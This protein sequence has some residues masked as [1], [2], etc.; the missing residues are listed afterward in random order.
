M[1]LHWENSFQLTA[2]LMIMSFGAGVF[3]SVL[4]MKDIE[5][6]RREHFKRELQNYPEPFVTYDDVKFFYTRI[7]LITNLQVID[8]T[9][10]QRF[11]DLLMVA[12]DLYRSRHSRLIILLNYAIP[13]V[14]RPSLDQIGWDFE[15]VSD[16]TCDLPRNRCETV[17]DYVACMSAYSVAVKA[18]NRGLSL[19]DLLDSIA[20]KRH[21]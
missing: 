14:F 4:I 5:A 2:S 11:D 15:D 20:S 10:N 16:I 18:L 13:I 21:N 17:G 9:A 6:R 8:I 7:S 12:E 19:K 3:V 1:I